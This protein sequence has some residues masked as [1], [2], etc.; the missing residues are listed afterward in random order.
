MAEKVG[1][2]VVKPLLGKAVVPDDSPYTTGGIGLLGTA[3]SQD[4]M[5][6][7]DTLIIVGSGFPYME[8]YPK[9]GKAKCVQIDIDPDRIGLRHPVDVGLVGDCQR[10]L[11]AL[12]PHDRAEEGPR[13]LETA[14]KGMKEWNAADGRARHRMDKPL[15]PQVVTHALN[16]FLADDAIIACDCG[17]VTTWAARYI[18]MR[19]KMLFSAS[20]MLATMGNGLPYAVGRRS[21]SRAGRWWRWSATAASP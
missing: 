20:G 14:Q 11:E 6:G 4:A 1:G 7:C 3:P 12:L 13:F 8:F 15:K 2:P 17:T 5:K 16:K 19:E 9:P 21:P 10:V 18:K